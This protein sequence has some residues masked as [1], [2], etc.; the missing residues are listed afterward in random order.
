M[1]DKYLITVKNKSG[2]SKNFL[3]FS[4]LPKLSQNVTDPYVNVWAKSVPVPSPNGHADFD[5]TVEQFAVCGTAPAPLAQGVVVSTGDFTPVT[6]TSAKPGTKAI[7]KVDDQG[8]AAFVPPAGT[9][10]VAHAFG[11]F[12]E[13]YSLSAHRGYS[14]FR[15]VTYM[16]TRN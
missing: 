14:V 6:V 3:L 12:V 4:D 15:A 1:T 11:I 13:P 7:M 5:I 10:D 9:T 16:G 8:G 2:L